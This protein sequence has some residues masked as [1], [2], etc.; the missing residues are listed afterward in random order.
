M[1]KQHF[2]G[3]G[4]FVKIIAQRLPGRRQADMNV[5]IDQQ[6]CA[7]FQ[8]IVFRR[9]LKTLQQPGRHVVFN[10][11]FGAHILRSQYLAHHRRAVNFIQQRRHA[12][13]ADGTEQLFVIQPLSVRF[14]KNGVPGAGYFSKFVVNRHGGEDFI[15]L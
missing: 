8:E 4:I 2:I 5:F 6:S 15:W 10:G 3:I 7:A 9:H 14:F 11:N 1:D 12:V 13:K